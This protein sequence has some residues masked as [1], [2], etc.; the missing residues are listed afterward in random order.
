[1]RKRMVTRT[2]K[3]STVEAMVTDI[4]E[5]KV[6]HKYVVIT[7]D[8]DNNTLA[9]MVKKTVEAEQGM[10]FACITEVQTEEHIYGMPEDEFLV[11]AK[12]ITR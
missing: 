2:I 9:K 6:F 4:V 1:M 11:Y 7:G 3:V 5:A 8:Y 10:V 12:E